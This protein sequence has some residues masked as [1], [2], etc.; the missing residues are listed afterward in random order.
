[1]SAKPVSSRLSPWQIRK[2][3][4]HIDAN[5][6]EGMTVGSLAG[7][8]GLSEAYFSRAFRASLGAPPHAFILDR[9]LARAMAMMRTSVRSLSDIAQDCGFC[10]QPHMTKHFSRAV[11]A[12]PAA[13]RRE[14]GVARSPTPVA[15]NSARPLPAGIAPR[16]WEG[17]GLSA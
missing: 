17:Q 2:I 11:G 15:P 1:M 6:T 13:W 10:D 9:R 16:A 12:S 7:I 5:L 4:S 14:Y 8:M 3:L